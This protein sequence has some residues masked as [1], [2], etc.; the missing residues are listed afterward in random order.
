MGYEGKETKA[1]LGEDLKMSGSRLSQKQVE[2]DFYQMCKAAGVPCWLTEKKKP[3]S[4]RRGFFQMGGAYGKIRVEYSYKCGGIS[5]LSG[6]RN[7]RDMDL[8]LSN[9]NPKSAYREYQKR[10]KANCES[11]ERRRKAM[12]GRTG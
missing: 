12:M 11:Q 9:F 2:D 4:K 10:D 3:N 5:D 1:L 7:A 6:Y 8:W